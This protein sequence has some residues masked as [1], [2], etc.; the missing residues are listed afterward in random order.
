MLA[1][2]S[3][4]AN[5]ES[6]LGQTELDLTQKEEVVYIRRHPAEELWAFVRR[7]DGGEGYVP[8]SYLYD[9]NASVTGMPWLESKK[10]KLEAEVESLPK[11]TGGTYK[12]YVSAYSREQGGGNS[13]GSGEE[14]Y[15]CDLCNK[16]F[17][18]PLPLQ[19][20]MS[21]KAHREEVELLSDY[22]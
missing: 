15:R 18:G 11:P 13:G 1:K 5:T 7:S 9:L 21:S 8:F 16:D 19:A 4:K 2:Y 12:P 20:H 17:N 3:Y 10:E 14:K 6:P 22:S